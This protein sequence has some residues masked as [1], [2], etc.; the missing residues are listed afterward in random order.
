MKSETWTLTEHVFDPD[1][2]P[3]NETLFALS[4]GYIGL[5]GDFEEGEGNFHPGTYINGF[6]EIR[7]IE[8]GEWGYG[9]AK[10]HQTIQNT[11]NPKLVRTRV[12]GNLIGVTRRTSTNTA[13]ISIFAAGPWNAV[14]LRN[15]PPGRGCATRAGAS[16]PWPIPTSRS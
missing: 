7:P 16:S 12:N 13:G 9:F 3:R 15:F 5:R 4:N 8:Y 11:A 2:I 1:L 10:F 14:C 6:Y